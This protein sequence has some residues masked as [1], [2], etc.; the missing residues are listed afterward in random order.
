MGIMAIENNF[1]ASLAIIN[2]LIKNQGWQLELMPPGYDVKSVSTWCHDAIG[3]FYNDMHMTGD[4]YAT[5]IPVQVIKA[6]ALDPLYYFAFGNNQ[7]R[8]MFKLRWNGQ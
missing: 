4:W 6:L 8:L 5:E 1:P 2:D 3:S 7:A